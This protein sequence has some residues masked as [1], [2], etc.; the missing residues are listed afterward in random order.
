MDAT[1][2]VD[3]YKRVGLYSDTLKVYCQ[4]VCSLVE[5]LERQCLVSTCHRPQVRGQGNLA[6][7]RFVNAFELEGRFGFVP[8]MHDPLEGVG[9]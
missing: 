4:S 6:L 9:G 5:F 3:T 8:A 2:D 1:I 7:D